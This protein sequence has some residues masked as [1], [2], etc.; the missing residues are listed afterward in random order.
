[1]HKEHKRTDEP[2]LREWGA[3][4]VKLLL[5]DQTS[6]EEEEEDKA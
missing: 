3:C 5:G 6:E 4:L 1:M 2:S